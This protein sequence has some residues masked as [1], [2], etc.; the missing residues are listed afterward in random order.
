MTLERPGEDEPAGDG[1]REPSPGAPAAGC[2]PKVDGRLARSART[3]AAVVDAFLQLL[4]EGDLRPT[5]ARVAD[6]A[7][8][9]RRSVYVHFRDL[10]TLFAAAA[11]RH[12]E[13]RLVPLL[14]DR[15]AM[16]EDLPCRIEMFV[17]LKAER[18]ELVTPVRRAA[19]LSEPFSKEVAGQLA[20]ARVRARAEVQ[21]VFAKELEPLDCERR[22]VVEEAILQA[23]SWT[24]WESM[25]RSSG[26][27]A[28]T[29]AAVMAHLLTSALAVGR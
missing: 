27:P 2:A 4:E 28:A 19:M 10:D 6:R 26:L 1:R 20:T 14:V 13:L 21:I 8:V 9:S 22:V 15:E 3:F 24:T 29:A 17:K 12:Y 18:L 16:P 7:G 5:A 11:D 25:R 23:V